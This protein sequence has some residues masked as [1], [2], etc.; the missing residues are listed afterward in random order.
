MALSKT[1][2]RLAQQLISVGKKRGE[3]GKEIKSALATAIVEANL[4]NPTYG[5]GTSVGWRQEIDTYGSVKNRTNIKKSANRYYDETSTVGHNGRGM[6]IGAL[7]QSVQRSAYPDR[8]DAV[9]GQAKSIYSDLL[10]KS[11]RRAPGGSQRG[12]KS[13][14]SQPSRSGR[15]EAKQNLQSAL[16][17][18]IQTPDKSFTDYLAVHDAQ[19][20]AKQAK[21][22]TKQAQFAGQKISQKPKHE[23]N[24]EVHKSTL[25]LPKNNEKAVVEIGKL[26]QRMGLSVGENPHFGGVAPVHA[27]GSYHYQDRAI[28]VSGDPRLMAK[29][30]NLVGKRYSSRLAEEFWNGKHAVNFKNGNPEPKGFVEGHQD[31]VHVAI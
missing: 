10:G 4:S 2:K 29:F 6:S 30:A 24:K 21:Q 13:S 23:S 9:A 1:Q 14:Q 12:R 22:A 31:H 8:Y 19:V 3:S 5:D 20:Q 15:L 16:F 11:L 27:T 17:N 26:A 18:F 7:S 25:K 28:D